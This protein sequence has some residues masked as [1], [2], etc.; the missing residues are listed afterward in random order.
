[1][2][3]EALHPIE[4]S[5]H[6]ES[7]MPLALLLPAVLLVI[8]LYL[9]KPKGRDY[10][11]SS[12]LLWNKLFKNQESKTFFEKFVHNILMYLQI[13]VIFLLVL[14]LMSPYLQ[15]EGKN[16]GNV[17][18]V[19]DTSG[20]MQHDTGEGRT[21]IEDALRQAENLI[22]ASEETAFSVIT[23][24]CTGANLLAAGV[25]DKNRLYELLETIS[26]CDGEAKLQAAESIVDTLRRGGAG[27]GQPEDA[28]SAEVIV[29]TDGSGAADAMNF[30]E[31]FDARVVVVG[32]KVSNVANNFLSYSFSD[33]QADTSD[34]DAPGAAERD[35]D[36]GRP[37]ICASG[38]TNYSDAEASME[39]SLYEG[40]KLLEIRQLTLGAGDTTLCLFEEFV[41][42]GEPLRSEISS[43]RFAGENKGYASHGGDSLPND[44]TA[45]AVL[46]SEGAVE[47]VLIGEGNTYIEKAYQAAAGGNMF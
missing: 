31:Y 39:V 40:E 25:K 3:N 38:I 41:W 20:S 36:G 6:F 18:L 19:L 16:G 30:S 43:V 44:N 23:S 22:A 21:R 46:G 2:I 42:Q 17:I 8:I 26:C 5:R 33:A 14:A 28:P 11:I 1:M 37:V 34:S 10:K 9:L 12:N 13:L 29:F 27:E 32:D 47:A 45:Y 15:R 4:I 7:L 24:D 35:G